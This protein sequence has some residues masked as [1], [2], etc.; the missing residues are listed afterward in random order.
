MTENT[1]SAYRIEAPHFVAGIK[2][3]TRSGVEAVTVAAPIVRWMIGKPM[4]HI[5]RYVLGKGWKINGD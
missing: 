1:L 5:V 2:T 4:D 3:E